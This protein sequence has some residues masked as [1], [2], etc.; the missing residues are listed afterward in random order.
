[1]FLD[2]GQQGPEGKELG[3]RG[4]DA[5]PGEAGGDDHAGSSCR[6][7]SSKKGVRGRASEA[8]E[9]LGRV[10]PATNRAYPLTTLCET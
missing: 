3:G 7:S 4:A 1:M 10:S 9:A 8:L 2:G 6:R 5:N